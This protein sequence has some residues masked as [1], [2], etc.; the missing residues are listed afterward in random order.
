[1]EFI[2]EY[3]GVLVGARAMVGGDFSIFGAEGEVAGFG[4]FLLLTG[5]CLLTK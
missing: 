3:M 2:A 4:C 1:V 5:T